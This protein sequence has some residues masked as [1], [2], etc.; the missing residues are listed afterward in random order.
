MILIIEII[1][2][3]GDILM[4]ALPLYAIFC[5]ERK[6]NNQSFTINNF[7]LDFLSK[8]ILGMVIC[9]YLK[10]VINKKTPD[11]NNNNSFPSG[12]TMSA[13]LSALYTMKQ[14]NKYDNICLFLSLFVGF[15]RIVSRKHYIIDVI[16]S[17]CISHFII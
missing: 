7:C 4:F 12:H 1:E 11:G 5:E 16:S 13:Y 15:S 2:I 14:K 8:Y 9:Y 3:I 6:T 17:M 10:F